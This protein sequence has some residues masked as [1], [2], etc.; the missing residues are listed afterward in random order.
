MP[1]TDRPG[2]AQNPPG[3][4]PPLRP[5]GTLQ[6]QD[7]PATSTWRWIWIA[8]GVVLS[9]TLLVVLVLPK[10]VSTPPVT[11]DITETPASSRTADA[12]QQL[13]ARTQAEQTLQSILRLQAQ[14]EQGNVAVW[15]QATWRAAADAVAVGDRSF[16]ERRFS[17][18]GQA[19]D[20]AL[21]SL[22]QLQQSRAQILEDAVTTGWQALDSD[23]A[24][25][26]VTQFELALA[27]EPD[28]VSATSGLARARLRPDVLQRMAE[29]EAAESDNEL[30]AAVDAYHAA[31]QLDAEYLPASDKLQRVTA[32][33]TD[34]AFRAAMSRALQALESGRLQQAGQALEQ[35]A[36]LKP[37][38]NAVQGTRQRLVQARRQASLLHLRR[39]AQTKTANEDWQAAVDLYTKALRVDA[40]VG[41]ARDGLARARQQLKL[42]Q[43]FDHYLNDP[44]RLYSAQPLANAEQLL[45]AVGDVPADKPRLTKKVVQLRRLVDAAQLPIVVSLTSDGETDVVVYRVARFGRFTARRLELRPG[46]YTVVGSRQGYRDVRKVFTVT[47]GQ[48]PPAIDIRCQER[49]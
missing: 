26:A 39:T 10:L 13:A 3:L 22:Q 14:L 36:Q 24:A 16:G 38:D 21:D 19:Y 8:L 20:E 30:Q 12:A 48:A 25:T 1:S 42:Y 18:A 37:E 34:I 49:I 31:Q 2:A 32:Q 46:N 23:A 5:P 35:A 17:A 44:S 15:G 40:N 6:P 45:A 7:D 47:P 41:F 43:Q 33:L 11:P 27:I 9:L 4:H 28:H 29:G